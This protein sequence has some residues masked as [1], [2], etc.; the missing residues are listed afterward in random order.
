[1]LC[2]ARFELIAI[3]A[4]LGGDVALGSH[5]VIG[6]LVLRGVNRTTSRSFVRRNNY[7]TD[8]MFMPQEEQ[9]EFTRILSFAL[10]DLVNARP[11]DPVK[12]LAK[13]LVSLLPPDEVDAEFSDLLEED[14]KLK[15]K[16]DPRM[17]TTITEN[18]DESNAG[19]S[20]LYEG[21][22]TESPERPVK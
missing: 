7:A 17:I 10:E 19:N 15:P 18:E 5:I 14:V 12:Y 11:A 9:Q 1:M 6:N 22:I 2:G 4:L 3:E 13:R 16:A 21:K 8:K 20:S